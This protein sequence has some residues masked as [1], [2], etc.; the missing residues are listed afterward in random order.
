MA[1]IAAYRRHPWERALPDPAA[2]WQ[3]GGSRLLDYGGDGP[4]V[5]F[6][7]SLVNRAYVLDLAPGRS[8]LRWLAGRGMRPLLLDWGWPG[9]VERRFT[10]TDY[11]AG[12]LE[13]ALA[14][15]AALAGE[16]VL[17]A[18]YCMGGTLAVAAAE[19]RPDL[20]RGLAL[21]AAPWDF[22]AGDRA[23]ALLAARCARLL[24]PIMA[25]SGTLPVDCLQ[26]LF[27]LLDPFGVAEKY[28]AFARL[29]PDSE[30]ARLFVALEDWLNDG[31]P[32]AAPVARECLTG[33]YGE[34]SPARGTW[35]VAGLAVEPRRLRMPCL[36]VAPGRDR[37]VPPA[38]ARVLA[39][40][41]DGAVLHEPAA[42]H[43][44]MAAGAG[45]E[46]ALW[47]VLA[48]WVAGR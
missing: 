30:R 8:M 14:T 33:W 5:L 20:V 29:D 16:P 25:A 38:S 34:N 18:G 43:I 47:S 17:L 32:L 27:A 46:Q 3:E 40:L 6:V 12:R 2:A 21:L 10:L 44:G 22:H 42:G 7:P 19:R 39:G 9:P 35:R 23:L 15:S 28:R 48:A 45:A 4:P 26:M 37:I 36:V 31:I 1:G 11:V 24:E 41:I 13:R